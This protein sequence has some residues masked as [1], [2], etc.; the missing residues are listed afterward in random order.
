MYRQGV[1]RQGVYR[2]GVYRPG[3]QPLA[4]TGFRRPQAFSGHEPS[5]ATEPGWP[6]RL[7][8]AFGGHRPSAATRLQRPQL[9]GGHRPAALGGHKLFGGSRPSAATSLRRPRRTGG[10]TGGDSPGTGEGLQLRKGV[11]RQCADGPR[12][13]QK[14]AAVRLV[15]PRRPNGLL[16]SLSPDSSNFRMSLYIVRIL[17][18][19][20]QRDRC[21]ADFQKSC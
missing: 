21:F 15:G 2:Q 14:T 9:F 3:L 19:A 18:L 6:I 11:R 8:P 17:D 5:A 12:R 10:A 13:G 1:Y 4:V 16:T 20:F 7:P